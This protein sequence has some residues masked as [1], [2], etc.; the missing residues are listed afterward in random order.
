MPD[1]SPNTN[2]DDY[3]DSISYEKWQNKIKDVVAVMDDLSEKLLISRRLRYP[4]IEIE[5][6]KEQGKLA[7]DEIYIPRHIIDTNIRKEQA[8]YIQYVTQSPRAIILQDVQ[9]PTNL[10]AELEHDATQKLRFNRWQRSMYSLIDGM[11]QNGYGVMELTQDLKQQ[12][13]IAHETVQMGDF[14][15]MQDTQDIQE[16]EIVMRAHYF[17]KTRLNELISDEAYGFSAEEV[18]SVTSKEPKNSSTPA[19]TVETTD[20]KDRSLYRVMKC[21]FRVKGVVQVAWCENSRC[22]DWLR[23]PKSLSL[24]RRRLLTQQEI[25]VKV[26]GLMAT[27][28]PDT[29]PS[30]EIQQSIQKYMNPAIPPSM[31][32]T[33]KQYPFFIAP[34]LISENDTISEHKGRA[35]LD[36]NA[37]E[38]ASSLLSSFLT[39]HRRASGLY[40]SKEVQDPNDD[41]LLQKNV[42]FKTGCLINSNVKQFQLQ[43]PEASMVGAINQIE[44]TN[45]SE[46]SQVAFAVNNRQ[47]SRKTATE[48]NA[49]VGQQATLSTVQVVLFATFLKDLYGT[50]FTIIQSRIVS[51]LIT[52]SPELLQMYKGTYVVKPS[53][54]TDVIERQQMVQQMMQAWPVMQNTP[55]NVAFL[56]DLLSRMFPETSQKYIAIFQQQEQQKQSQQA[57]QM[58]A[59]GQMLQQAQ[60]GIE[61]LAKHREFFSE[62]GLVNAYPQIQMAAEKAQQMQQSQQPQQGQ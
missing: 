53:G 19:T 32:D 17:T 31:E 42:Y 12:G 11:Q 26:Q 47:D 20:P 25:Q 24:G 1:T 30:T 9:N 44:T 60:G 48:T 29:M 43:A 38:S 52:V 56:S 40:F 6:E 7:P 36:Q 21:M 58:Q 14:G 28:P 10:V 39:A 18:A 41:V 15:Y 57:Q 3:I 59:M 33:E 61:M 2:Q 23:K 45:Q 4:E 35:W 55:A 46:T 34:Y 27:I 49:A 54:D 16:S 37:Q 62:S 5:S 50:A 8:P 22:K 13:E 51:G